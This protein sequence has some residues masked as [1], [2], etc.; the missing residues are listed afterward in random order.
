MM[1]AYWTFKVIE[2]LILLEIYQAIT[3]NGPRASR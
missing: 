3:G 1:V 2:V